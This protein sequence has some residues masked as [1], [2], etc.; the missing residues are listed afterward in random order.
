MIEEIIEYKCENCGSTHLNREKDYFICNACGSKFYIKEDNQNTEPKIEI[1]TT[2]N[3]N[4]SKN[5]NTDTPDYSDLAI[6]CKG[7]IYILIWV[8]L[9]GYLTS[10]MNY[11][12]GFI[13][14]TVIIILIA[15]AVHK[16][17]IK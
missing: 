11:T 17:T 13:L 12:V 2:S 14:S 8:L 15:Y 10:R 1:K 16:L 3:R 5:T 4:T 6:C 9:L 7:F